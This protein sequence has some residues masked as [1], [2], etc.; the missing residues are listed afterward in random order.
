ML[1]RLR[2]DDFE[3]Q[4]TTSELICTLASRFDAVDDMFILLGL[5][6]E[7]SAAFPGDR[8]YRIAATLHDV[9]S[10]IEARP[11]VQAYVAYVKRLEATAL[12]MGASV[13]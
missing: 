9:A 13:Q 6:I 10:V 7:V 3:Q 1:C 4:P 2:D 5:M 11:E 8:Q 12:E